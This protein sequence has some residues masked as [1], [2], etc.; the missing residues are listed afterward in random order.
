MP[1]YSYKCKCGY[2]YEI[3]EFGEEINKPHLCISCGVDMEREFC[4]SGNFILKYDPRADRVSW[5]GE[6]YSSTRHY[7][8]YDKKVSKEK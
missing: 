1:I 6:G 7:E 3:L 4:P 8:E 5:G 2:A